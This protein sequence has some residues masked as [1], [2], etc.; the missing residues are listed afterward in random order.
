MDALA[1]R[2]LQSLLRAVGQEVTAI[3]QERKESDDGAIERLGPLHLQ[4]NGNQVLSLA[5]VA[6]TADL[7]AR[8][9]ATVS[10]N[11][12]VQPMN[13]EDG[14]TVVNVSSGVGLGNG[15]RMYL[16]RA[17]LLN[18]ESG[19]L[20]GVALSLG[21]KLSFLC[22]CDEN[23]LV[24]VEDVQTRVKESGFSP[25][26]QLS[27]GRPADT[28]ND[29]DLSPLTVI[30]ERAHH[31]DTEV[32]YAPLMHNAFQTMRAFLMKRG[33]A[34]SSDAIGDLVSE[35]IPTTVGGPLDPSVLADWEDAIR[36]TIGD[37]VF[38]QINFTRD[39]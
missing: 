25:Y 20:S 9:S 7:D 23:T 37:S 14:W 1:E 34:Q 31:T 17:T 19:V 21:R 15:F 18:D 8:L 12:E 10:P 16:D 22:A 28:T 4:L 2:L 29:E 3:Y 30:Y 11:S 5:G 32:S 38:D 36:E 35:L 39:S 6:P 13:Q 27:V 33:E 26:M 24:H